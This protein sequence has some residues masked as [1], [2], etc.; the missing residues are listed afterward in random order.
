MTSVFLH[1]HAVPAKTEPIINLV[2]ACLLVPE[3]L[4]LPVPSSG[5]QK[6]NLQ[7]DK[8]AETGIWHTS[9]W[10]DYIQ[11]QL[12]LCRPTTK[13]ICNGNEEFANASR[14]RRQTLRISCERVGGG[15]QMSWSFMKG[16]KQRVW[17]I[18]CLD[19]ILN[20]QSVCERCRQTLGM[21]STYQNK[22]K[23]PYQHVTGSI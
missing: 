17:K 11:E 14:I 9:K 8:N 13:I 7:P 21:S 5:I 15:L 1:T 3:S 10:C 19:L 23:C 2:R 22:T 16:V 6:I 12:Y 4:L 20:T 18:Y